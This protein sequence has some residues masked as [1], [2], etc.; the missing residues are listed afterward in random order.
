V[1]A[2]TCRNGEHFSIDPDAIER[3]EAAGEIVVHM[4]DG[5]KYV[6]D[7]ALDELVAVVRDH[8]AAA[9]AARNRLADGFS[10]APAAT[11]HGRRVRT[12]HRPIVGLPDRSED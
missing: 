8:R 3:V 12:D 10:A 1:I 11:R 9:L 4:V 5:S 7:Q 6:I 2:V